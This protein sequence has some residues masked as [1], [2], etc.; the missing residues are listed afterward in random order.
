MP[1]Q[2]HSDHNCITYASS[3]LSPIPPPPLSPQILRRQMDA[4]RV[5]RHQFYAVLY[6]VM[7]DAAKEPLLP[8]H[9]VGEAVETGEGTR[10]FG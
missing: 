8:S 4:L 9:A 2:V 6:D 1:L 3:L 10:W 5:D 7:F